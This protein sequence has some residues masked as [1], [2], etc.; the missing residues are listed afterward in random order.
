ML[1][2]PVT[3]DVHLKTMAK[4]FNIAWLSRLKS[5]SASQLGKSIVRAA[6]SRNL[7]VA[8]CCTLD[9]DKRWGWAVGGGVRGEGEGKTGNF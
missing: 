3:I 1:R 7:I 2:A 6:I 5:Y 9:P 8:V 4:N